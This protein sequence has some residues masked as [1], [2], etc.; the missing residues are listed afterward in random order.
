MN[1]S[2]N[3]TSVAMTTSPSQTEPEFI[4]ELASRVTYLQRHF[5]RKINK[6]TASSGISIPQYTLLSYLSSCGELTMGNLAQYMG[7]TTPA[8]T[9]LVDR[10][11]DAGYVERKHAHDDRRKV[12]VGI[13]KK[14]Q[15]MLQSYRDE[16][17]GCLRQICQRLTPEDQNAWLRI[18]GTVGEYCREVD[19]KTG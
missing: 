10:L 19:E 6:N 2:R 11:S 4:E 13:T 18:Y 3:T 5:L 17:I 7:H 12:H 1:Y 15:Q 16:L 9:G 8:T 14:G